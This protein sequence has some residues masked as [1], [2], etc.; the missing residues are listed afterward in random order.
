MPSGGWLFVQNFARK[1]QV[2]RIIRNA[3]SENVHTASSADAACG[4]EVKPRSA[5]G[6]RFFRE[7]ALISLVCC[8]SLDSSEWTGYQAPRALAQT[9]SAWLHV[10]GRP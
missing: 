9:P 6:G 4:L 7:I 3:Q 2:F 1:A 5:T 8:L 10:S